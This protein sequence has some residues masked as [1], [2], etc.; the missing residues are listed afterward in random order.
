MF[1]LKKKKKTLYILHYKQS[2]WLIDVTE[3]ARYV[4]TSCEWPTLSPS[5]KYVFWLIIQEV[6]RKKEM[7][8]YYLF[9]LFHMCDFSFETRWMFMLSYNSFC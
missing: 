8:M 7:I 2:N 1:Y 4:I 3:E 5:P 6:A 9:L